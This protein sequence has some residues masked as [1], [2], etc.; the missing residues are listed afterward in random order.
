[1]AENC[2]EKQ[3]AC[4]APISS[5]GLV[6]PSSAKREPNEYAPSISPDSPL[7]VPLPPVRSPFHSALALLIAILRSLGLRWP[8]SG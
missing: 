4:A 5:S 7:N 6:P 1:M 8:R 3:L 2:I